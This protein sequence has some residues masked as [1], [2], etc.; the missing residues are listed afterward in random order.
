MQ[1]QGPDPI[2]VAVKSQRIYGAV[3]SVAF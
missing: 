2:T 1:M 3:P